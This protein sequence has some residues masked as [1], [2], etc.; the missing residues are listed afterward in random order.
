MDIFDPTTALKEGSSEDAVVQIPLAIY[1]TKDL[2]ISNQ[3]SQTS[4][5]PS[6]EA[7]IE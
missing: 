3:I 2:S 6:S 5:I 4:L 1:T 7:G